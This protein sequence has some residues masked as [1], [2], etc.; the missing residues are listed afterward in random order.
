MKRRESVEKS[1]RKQFKNPMFNNRISFGEVLY[2]L[3]HE[4]TNKI[5]KGVNTIVTK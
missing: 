5:L 1:L 2:H 3:P 4:V